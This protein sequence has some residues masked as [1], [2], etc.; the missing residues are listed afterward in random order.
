M[1]FFFSSKRMATLRNKRKFAAVSEETQEITRKCQSQ[2]TFVP[3]MTKE[4]ITQLSKKIEWKVTKKLSQ[5]FSRTEPRILGALSKLDDF[6]WNP[7]IRTFSGSVLG[8]SRDNDLENRNQLGIVLRMIPI[9]K[10]SS[11]LVGPAIRLT[12]IKMR[13]LTGDKTM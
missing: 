8:T 3:S 2:K 10:W 7:Q 11:L 1:S 12:Q 13:L 6:L 4:Y 9:P 5:E